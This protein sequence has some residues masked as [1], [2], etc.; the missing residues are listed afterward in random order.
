MFINEQL[1]LFKTKS[2]V[3]FPFLINIK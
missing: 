1:F 2:R 3:T